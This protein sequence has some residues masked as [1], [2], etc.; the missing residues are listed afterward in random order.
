VAAYQITDDP[1]KDP[2]INYALRVL[3]MAKVVSRRAAWSF[4]EHLTDVLRG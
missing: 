4:A 1:L 3:A 2:G